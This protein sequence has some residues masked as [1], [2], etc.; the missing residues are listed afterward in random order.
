MSID[1]GEIAVATVNVDQAKKIGHDILESM[2]GSPTK[3]YTFKKK[4]TAITMKA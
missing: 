2:C 4:Y 1:T 3:D